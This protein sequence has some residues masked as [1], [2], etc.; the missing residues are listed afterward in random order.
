M[1]SQALVQTSSSSTQVQR[2]NSQNAVATPKQ[3]GT[4]AGPTSTPQQNSA[5][6]QR[7]PNARSP[8]QLMQRPSPAPLTPGK[9]EHPRMAEIK[10]RQHRTTFDQTHVTRIIGSAMVLAAITFG[11]GYMSRSCVAIQAI[12]AQLT[13]DSLPQALL[14]SIPDSTILVLHALQL[15][16]VANI[17]VACLPLLRKKDNMEDIPLTP[18]QRQLLDLPP[19]SRPAT[20][21]EQAAW[22]TP[23]RY[24]RSSTPT[25][26]DSLKVNARGTPLSARGSPSGGVL[27]STPPSSMY[28]GRMSSGSVYA[29][30][31]LSGRATDAGKARRDSLGSGRGSPLAD[32]DIFGTPMTK[33]SRAS[34]GLNNKW[35][36]DKGKVSPAPSGFLGTGW[37]T[38]SVFN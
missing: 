30:S 38:G 36:Y 1:S 13:D 35:L 12:Y 25:S 26:M 3:A 31:P 34:V 22:V 23:P 14:R 11:P 5:V 18:Q 8:Q 24:S 9:W 32:K 6:L 33:S 16:L 10:R 7:T 17:T 4:P 27:S 29:G 28:A 21:Q 2:S 15:L 37:G 19:M 20:P